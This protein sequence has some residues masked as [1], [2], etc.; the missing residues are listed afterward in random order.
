MATQVIRYVDPD[1]VG[2]ANGTSW[3]D[4]YTS[5]NA[6]S[7]AETKNLV[8]ADEQH[9]VYCRS[10]AGTA[11]TTQ[12]NMSVSWVTDATRYIEIIQTDTPAN[13]VFSTSAYR[14][15]Q[16]NTTSACIYTRPQYIRFHGMQLQMTGAGSGSAAIY[17]TATPAGGSDIRVDSCILYGGGGSYDGILFNDANA[18]TRV[19][20][21]TIT[22][23]RYGCN[24]NQGTV[25]IYNST[26]YGNTQGI[27]RNF[28]GTVAVKNCA[29]GNNNDDFFGS[30]GTIDYCASDD[31]DGTNA[32]NLSPGATEADDW[33]AAWTD[34]SNG[35]F[36]VKDTD[37][38][39]YDAG[40]AD[41]GSGLYD[42]DIRGVSR[43]TWDI[44]AFE[45]GP[46]PGEDPGGAATGPR[47]LMGCHF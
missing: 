7:T 31:G 39:L 35:D 21:C 9:T 37:S 24:V 6:W 11:D 41:P 38:V 13:R 42:D 1:A 43:S 46:D 45:Y 33:A 20:N 12:V 16:S 23:F 2:A 14:L 30:I 28:A 44:G 22:G 32:V 17:I 47:I 34:P 15:L 26:I 25:G 8:T 5:L 10:S 40:V 4:A 29:L 27:R 18:S 3:A 36:H 19:Y